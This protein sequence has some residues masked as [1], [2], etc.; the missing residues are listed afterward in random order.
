[1]FVFAHHPRADADRVVGKRSRWV[2]GSV[3]RPGTFS[4]DYAMR[5]HPPIGS[6][7]FAVGPF[8]DLGQHTDELRLLLLD[9]AV[10]C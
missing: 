5:W 8:P 2:G 10:Y 9:V 4:R 7:T 1:M 6:S 3:G